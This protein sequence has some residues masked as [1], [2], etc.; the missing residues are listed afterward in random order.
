MAGLVLRSIS[1]LLEDGLLRS[2]SHLWLSGW[3]L[4]L[5]VAP[6]GALRP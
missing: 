1:H 3:E 6:G 5:L 4:P 2:E